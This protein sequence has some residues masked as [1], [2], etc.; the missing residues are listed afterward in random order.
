MLCTGTLLRLLLAPAGPADSQGHGLG[1]GALGQDLCDVDPP[2]QAGTRHIQVTECDLRRS[3][4]GQ[5][6]SAAE[7]IKSTL[8]M[9]LVKKSS[10]CAGLSCS[11][12]MKI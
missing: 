4:V 12:F 1:A 10:L 11:L 7:C 6:G 2:L 3:G 8:S 9:I 5:Q